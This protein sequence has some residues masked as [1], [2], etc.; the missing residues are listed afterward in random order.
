MFQQTE[1]L[2]YMSIIH[3]ITI[4]IN[5]H[6]DIKNANTLQKPRS[7]TADKYKTLYNIHAPST[8][9]GNLKSKAWLTK[10]VF[11]RDVTVIKDEVACR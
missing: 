1:T 10:K 11:F 7:V 9:H 5:C 2:Y 8:Y 3:G 4:N 6:I